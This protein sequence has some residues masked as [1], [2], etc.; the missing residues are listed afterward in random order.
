MTNQALYI[1]KSVTGIAKQLSNDK[2]K[3][4]SRRCKFEVEDSWSHDYKGVMRK[5]DRSLKAEGFAR[6]EMYISSYGCPCCSDPVICVTINAENL[7]KSQSC[8]I[9]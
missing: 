9:S 3:D 7:E 1:I 5:I 2:R 8:P 4:G 6:D